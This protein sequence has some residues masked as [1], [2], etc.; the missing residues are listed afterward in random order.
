[1]RIEDVAATVRDKVS[2]ETGKAQV[3]DVVRSDLPVGGVT[4]VETRGSP[5]QPVAS[6]EID[7]RAKSAA[8]RCADSRVFLAGSC[9]SPVHRS[10]R[11]GDIRRS[12]AE[13]RS[14]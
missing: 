5:G 10:A 8:R 12:P 9:A 6:L 11:R 14:E 13:D 2:A 4:L 7:A 1:M 3:P